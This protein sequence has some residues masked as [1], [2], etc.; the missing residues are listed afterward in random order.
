MVERLT[1]QNPENGDT[2]ARLAPR[3]RGALGGEAAPPGAA[4]EA[5]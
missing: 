3:L 4:A 1:Y 5:G 2:V